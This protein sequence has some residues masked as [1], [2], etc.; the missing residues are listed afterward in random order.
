MRVGGS[1]GG[2]SLWLQAVAFG[3]RGGRLEAERSE[4]GGRPPRGEGGRGEVSEAA[5]R[6]GGVVLVPEAV[7]EVSGLGERCEDLD[8][9][10]LVRQLAVEALDVGVLPGTAGLDEERSGVDAAEPSAHFGSDKLRAVVRA[11]VPWDAALDDDLG[12]LIDDVTRRDVPCSVQAQALSGVFVDHRQD[13]DAT[14]VGRSVH[15]E[16]VGPDVVGA[17][18]RSSG[19]RV[20]RMTQSASFPALMGHAESFASPDPEHLPQ[21]QLPAEAAQEDTDTPVPVARVARCQLTDVRHE[22][23]VRRGRWCSPVPL[24]RARLPGDPTGAPFRDVEALLQVLHGATPADRAQSTCPVTPS[25]CPAG[26]S[27]G[28]GDGVT[29]HVPIEAFI[30]KER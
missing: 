1:R 12:Q 18:R 16:V 23:S 20:A 5:V 4:A 13:L 22:R 25:P 8:V 3:A 10:Q 2:S 30:S 29:G 17:L 27:T 11:D 21:A 6:P 7:G 19:A 24:R 26:A 28:H 14:A 15:D 9:Q